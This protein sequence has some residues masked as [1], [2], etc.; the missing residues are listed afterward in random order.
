MVDDLLTETPVEPKNYTAELVG[1]DKKFKDVEGLAKGKYEADRF[2]ELKN[3]QYDELMAD[4][5]KLLDESKTRARLEDLISDAEKKLSSNTPPEVNEVPRPT[6]RPEDIET[7]V[8]RKLTEKEAARQQQSNF[9]SVRRQLTEQIGD[10]YAPVVRKRI[11]ELGLTPEQFNQWARQAPKAALAAVVPAQTRE[12]FEAPP[13]TNNTFRPSSQPKRTWSYYKE[14][15]KAD[16]KSFYDKTI[17]NQMLADA[18]ALGAE[19]EDGDFN[20][21]KI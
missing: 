17:M 14:L 3:R 6:V 18:E 16:P 20:S 5:T 1:T 7:L 11:E 8:D 15:R 21:R 12:S 19:F 4:Y 2:I 10:N 9:E 13:R